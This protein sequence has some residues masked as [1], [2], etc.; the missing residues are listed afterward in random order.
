MLMVF[1]GLPEDVAALVE[2][3]GMDDVTVTLVNTSPVHERE[4]VAQLGAF[5]EHQGLAIV[6]GGKRIALNAPY[7][8]VRLAPGT[9]ETLVITMKRYANAPTAAFPW[10]R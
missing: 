8:S 3:I 10:D 1:T 4:V 6:V 9:G 7:F 5:A 2:K